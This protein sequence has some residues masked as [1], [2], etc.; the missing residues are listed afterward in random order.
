MAGRPVAN[1]LLMTGTSMPSSAGI[2]MLRIALVSAGQYCN[3]STHETRK[4]DQM[5][6]QHRCEAE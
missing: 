3:L 5:R 2:R 1:D 4:T 6:P